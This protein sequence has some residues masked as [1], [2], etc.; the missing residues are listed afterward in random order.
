MADRPDRLPLGPADQASD[1]IDYFVDAPKDG[2]AA[3][4][5]VDTATKQRI[6]E[7]VQSGATRYRTESDVLRAAIHWFLHE[8]IA[9]RMDGRFQADMRLAHACVRRAQAMARVQDSNCFVRD[10]GA[11]LRALVLQGAMDQAVEVWR[12]SLRTIEASSEPFRSR[13]L[14]A[15]LADPALEMVRQTAEAS[16]LGDTESGTADLGL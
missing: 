8:R 9:P 16:E 2:V 10:I 3:G 11:S 4:C 5:R 7:V 14:A 13:S 12:D 15:L 6:A 1:P